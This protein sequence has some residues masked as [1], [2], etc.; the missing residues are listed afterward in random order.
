[1]RRDAFVLKSFVAIN[2]DLRTHDVCNERNNPPGTS[3]R[4]DVNTRAVSRPDALGTEFSVE[5]AVVCFSLADDDNYRIMVPQ[6]LKGDCSSRVLE[7]KCEYAC[8]KN[9]NLLLNVIL[10]SYDRKRREQHNNHLPLF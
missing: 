10:R 4:R 2:L 8:K 3:P 7:K 9:S 6:P 5:T 1:M